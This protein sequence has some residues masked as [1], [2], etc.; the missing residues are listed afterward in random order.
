MMR[1]TLLFILSLFFC[2]P[3][4]AAAN[5]A[6]YLIGAGDVLKISVYDHSDMATTARVGNDGTVQF[7]LVG[8]V[9]LAGL[10]VQDA[11]AEL[12][13]RLLD[14]YLANPQVVVFITAYRSK[15]VT[16][17][18]QVR[19]SGVLELSGPTRLLDVLSLVGGLTENAGDVATITRA[20]TTDATAPEIIQIDLKRLMETGDVA[21]N[22]QI[23][24]K[25]NVFIAKAGMFYVTGAVNSPNAYKYEDGS[26]VLK[27]LSMAGGFTKVAA[28]GRIRIVRI[29]DGKEQIME[30]VA[31]QEE[32]QAGDVIV[33]PESYF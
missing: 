16:V 27:A 20:S 19:T 33:V 11:V 10:T 9:T 22:I 12:Q 21:L 6:D 7:P 13:T 14:G 5:P 32:L 31:L 8:T 28:K 18:G 26:T 24:D 17:I 23:R 25:D 29:V 3:A 2:S 30:K 1:L 4:L 15:R